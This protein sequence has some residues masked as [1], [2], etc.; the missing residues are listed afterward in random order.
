MPQGAQA[1]TVELRDTVVPGF[2]CKITPAD[3]KVFMFQY[4]TKAGERG[5]E[6]RPQGVDHE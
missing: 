4:R 1:Q 5:Q 3:R 6:C 2:L